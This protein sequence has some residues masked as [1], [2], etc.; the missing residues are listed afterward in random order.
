MTDAARIA[1]A[2]AILSVATDD[3]RD[4]Q[5]LKQAGLQVMALSYKLLAPPTN[6]DG[7]GYLPSRHKENLGEPVEGTVPITPIVLPPIKTPLHA[8]APQAHH[9]LDI[10]Q[11]VDDTGEEPGLGCLGSYRSAL[12]PAEGLTGE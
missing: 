7:P 4:V 2:N 12:Y 1:L 5:V 6:D 10:P 8:Q 3:S 9:G 11:L